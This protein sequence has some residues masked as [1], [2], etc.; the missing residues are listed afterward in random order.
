MV[1]GFPKN[2]WPWIYIDP[3]TCIDCGACIPECPYAAIFPEDE[4]PSA[5]TG[6]TSMQ[7]RSR[8][9]RLVMIWVIGS[10]LCEMSSQRNSIITPQSEP[11]RWGQSS[12]RLG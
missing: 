4:V 6:H 8:T 11:N 2:E 10:L 5:S 9:Q 3:D 12:A 1:P 7:P